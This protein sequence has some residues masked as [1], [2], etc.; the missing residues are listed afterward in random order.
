[1][2]L[3]GRCDSFLFLTLKE[4]SQSFFQGFSEQQLTGFSSVGLTEHPQSTQSDTTHSNKG[5]NARG[6]LK[7]IL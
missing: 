6:M 4:R 2:K 1:M 7:I 5:N 3:H